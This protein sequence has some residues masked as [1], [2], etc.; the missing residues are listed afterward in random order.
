M[1]LRSSKEMAAFF[2]EMLNVAEAEFD[3]EKYAN[4]VSSFGNALL[5]EMS[6][7]LKASGRD[8]ARGALM[9]EYC[10]RYDAVV[11]RVEQKQPQQPL[12]PM[13]R[14]GLFAMYL[15]AMEK[16]PHFTTVL[17]P[18]A[19]E[20]AKTLPYG[21]DDRAIQALLFSY[22]AKANQ[23]RQAQYVE[24]RQRIVSLLD[25]AT[26]PEELAAAVRVLNGELAKQHH[27]AELKMFLY[28]QLVL[29]FER[30]RGRAVK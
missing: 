9:R 25:A 17:L 19:E 22:R 26:T 11:H 6:S 1:Q 28:L 21:E 12:F 10:Q 30:I 20:I 2:F 29:A 13:F 27:P 18:D 7:K 23:V 5:S 14:G 16:S 4:E 8:E 3:F 24:V 15:H